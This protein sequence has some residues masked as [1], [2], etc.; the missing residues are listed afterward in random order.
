MQVR[1]HVQEPEPSPEGFQQGLCSSAG[2]AFLLSWG[3]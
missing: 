2:G 1:K 3:A